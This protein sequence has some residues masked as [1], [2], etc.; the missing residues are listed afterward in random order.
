MEYRGGMGRST[1][2]YSQEYYL[3]DCEGWAQYAASK[4]RALSPRL[5]SLKDLA[6]FSK[7]ERVLDLG[8]GR[9]EL[10]LHAAAA[11]CAAVGIDFSPAA[12][13]LAR[14]AHTVWG[15]KDPGLRRAGFIQGAADALPFVDRCFD[16][17]LVSDLVEH[18]PPAI[19]AQTLREARRV[20]KP[21]GRMI[22][23]SS[24][25]RLFMA[26][27]LRLYW[28]LGRIYGLKLPWNMRAALPRGC[29]REWHL[30]EQTLGSL[31]RALKRAAATLT[32]VH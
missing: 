4:G 22:M 24:P 10:S 7:G 23:H 14:A 31:R 32:S 16:L 1:A 30:N 17:I 20:V 3:K 29:G 25:N 21:Q 6:R 8:C 12:L 27:G 11:G 5:R 15:R 13:G 26:W 2:V 19:L 18:L 28:L 9:G